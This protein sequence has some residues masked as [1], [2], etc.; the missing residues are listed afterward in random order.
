MNF[1]GNIKLDEVINLLRD[2]FRR[3]QLSLFEL[4]FL[5]GAL[6]V[7]VSA[8]YYY[9]TRIQ[10]LNSELSRLESRETALVLQLTKLKKESDKLAEQ[11]ANDGKILE[12]L[13]AFENYLKTDKSG[14][15]QIINE[16]STLGKT[17]RV[18]DGDMIFRPAEP[19]ATTD[20]NGNPTRVAAISN[21]S[22]L[23]IYPVLG[24]ETTILGDYQSLRRF[25]TDL[26]R[27]KQFLIINSLTF[28][29]EAEGVRR[30]AQPGFQGQ[31][32]GQL[33]DPGAVP[34]TLKIELDT[35]FNK[36]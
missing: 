32:Q 1:P 16:I 25:L 36:Q 27:S 22:E 29:G 28:Q 7:A 23:K 15:T 4:V 30:P 17:Y 9:L 34:V 12:S 6:L 18:S 35:Y 24:I 2:R 31:G 11:K 14:Q 33:T 26:E 13:K 21:I 5:I 10:P 8:S 3:V 19:D 20:A